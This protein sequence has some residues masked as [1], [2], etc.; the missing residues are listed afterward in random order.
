MN[1]TPDLPILWYF[2]DPMCSWCWGFSPAIIKAK[3][4]YSDR[5]RF[6]LN[7][8]GLRPGTTEPI[9]DSAREEI[10]HHWRDVHRLSNQPFKFDGAMSEGFIYDTEPASRAVLAF[11]RL[12]PDG[13]LDYFTAIQSA[14]YAE[15][16]NV[17]QEEV[18]IR[19]ATD[20]EVDGEEFKKLFAS[21]ELRQ[22]T[23]QH[24]QRT[25]KAGVRGFP[26]V[27]WHAGETVELLNNGYV[28]Y[29]MLVENI[30]SKLRLVKKE[31]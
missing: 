30:E 18:L 10:L 8:G 19:I 11:G 21:D 5:V 29:E 20:H 1:D 17:T 2:A 6:S 31:T 26:T 27:I 15:G 22:M 24:F 25:R 9:T 12:K 7:L 23:Q 4:E 28:P 3:K 13:V 14:F 16:Q